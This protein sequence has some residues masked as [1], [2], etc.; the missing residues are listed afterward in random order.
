MK[1]RGVEFL[2]KVSCI[3]IGCTTSC[4]T[5]ATAIV[6]AEDGEIYLYPTLPDGWLAVPGGFEMRGHHCPTHARAGA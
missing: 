5:P 4:T 3:A 1:P 6:D 2:V